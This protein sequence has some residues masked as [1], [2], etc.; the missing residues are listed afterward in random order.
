MA[1][2][3][4]RAVLNKREGS[5]EVKGNVVSFTSADSSAEA[6]PAERFAASE[7]TQLLRS[8]KDETVAKIVTE[9]GN[10]Y[11]ARFHSLADREALI[12]AL[13]RAQEASRGDAAMSVQSG[14]TTSETTEQWVSRSICQ[15]A[16]DVGALS[17][18]ELEDI[19][20]GENR[21]GVVQ[22]FDAL[23]ALVDR[24][25]FRLHPLT[26]SMENDVLRQIPILAVIFERHVMDEETKRSFWEAVVRKYFCFSRTFLEE[27]LERVESEAAAANPTSVTLAPDSN[28]SNGEPNDLSAI[29]SLSWRALPK[30]SE[31]AAAA[32]ALA[33]ADGTSEEEAWAVRASEA[34]GTGEEE[35]A[36]D[37]FVAYFRPTRTLCTLT[38]DPGSPEAL[39]SRIGAQ[40]A[41]KS[42]VFTGRRI[43]HALPTEPTHKDALE[44]LRRFWRSNDIKQRAAVLAQYETA[45]H[46][47]PRRRDSFI[48]S[49]CLQ[50]AKASVQQDRDGERA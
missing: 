13:V 44:T 29:N 17:R 31:T 38:P 48:E 50:Q 14:P 2:T 26:E 5:I 30:L 27:E 6:L 24:S 18:A 41:R 15:A 12:E 39:P 43:T 1:S 4:V 46:A 19:L 36:Q 9:A 45:H 3:R 11:V 34:L 7:V 16:V 25:T 10:T 42:A 47:G 35:Y 33:E 21:R 37:R 8:R 40:C 23:E 28:S 20:V 32:A 22:A 49:T